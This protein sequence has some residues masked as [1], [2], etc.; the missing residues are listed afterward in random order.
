MKHYRVTLD[1]ALTDSQNPKDWNWE[2]ILNTEPN[3]V[4]N[5]KVETIE[6]EALPAFDLRA[7]QR[8]KEARKHG[9]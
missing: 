8:V 3:D 4:R 2:Y 1:M 5:V 9:R 6:N 7:L